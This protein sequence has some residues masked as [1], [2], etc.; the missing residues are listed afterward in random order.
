MRSRGGASWQSPPA[1]AC[2]SITGPLGL[3]KQ[4]AG[5]LTL[6]GVS[7]YTG[8][9]V[10]SAGI[11]NVNADPALGGPA[12]AVTIENNATLQAGGPV[13]VASRTITLGTGGGKIDTNGNTVTLDTGST[14]TGTT[15][16][17]TGTGT[18]NLKGSQTYAALTTTAGTTNLY[19]A[20][21]T[22]TSTL[23]ANATTNIY[24]SQTLASL[25][26]ADGV[27]VTFGDGL[28]FAGGSDKFGG[29]AAVVPEPGS[30]ALLLAGAL[31]LAARRR[32]G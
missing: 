11:L 4:G 19:S 21:G 26:I 2:G 13:T 27:E 16:E 6:S 25:T 30:M 23:T 7:T 24:A 15:L 20:L 12:G 22:G 8:G 18:L 29:G 28:P 32:R 10:I 9:T 3:K 17:K 14:V 31:G 1:G 5:T